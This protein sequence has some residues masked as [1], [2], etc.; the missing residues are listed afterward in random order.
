MKIT[1]LAL[2]FLTSTAFAQDPTIARREPLNGMEKRA[3][4]GAT[5]L[6]DGLRYRTCPRT[7]CSAPGQYPKGTKIK[8]S[9][10]T[11]TDT[12]TV[13]GDKGWAKVYGGVGDGRWVAL[14][15]ATYV[16][17]DAPLSAC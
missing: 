16:T 5:V 11:R 2:A 7:S 3:V 15:G 9:C 1:A 13:N 14:A 6:V 10:F 17:W 4:V 12:T 8:L